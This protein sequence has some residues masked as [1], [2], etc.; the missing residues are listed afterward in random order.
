[1]DRNHILTISLNSGVRAYDVDRFESYYI[2]NICS[3]GF[4]QLSGHFSGEPS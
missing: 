4:S 1:M 3:T 2:E